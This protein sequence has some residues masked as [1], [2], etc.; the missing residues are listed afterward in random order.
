MMILEII[1][2][3]VLENSNF[4]TE[5]VIR[6]AVFGF[7]AILVYKLTKYWDT[8]GLRFRLTNTLI[9]EIE[10]IIESITSQNQSCLF[11]SRYQSS[12]SRSRSRHKRLPT[13]YG[14][15]YE[16]LMSSGNISNF[17]VN[18]QKSLR[19]FYTHAKGSNNDTINI[20]LS[21]LE[22]VKEIRHKNR[23]ISH[24]IKRQRY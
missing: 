19:F 9:L 4:L 10:D 15:I 7:V 6:G 11:R 16:G 24:K 23:P 8:R 22:I 14:D 1:F 17:D 21:T 3:L 2:E 18:V 13:A 12:L 5:N 20:A